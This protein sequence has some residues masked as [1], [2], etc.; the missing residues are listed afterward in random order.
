MRYHSK[1]LL[2]QM[3]LALTSPA[4]S[5]ERLEPRLGQEPIVYSWVENGS[6]VDGSDCQVH[7]VLTQSIAS[8]G[9]KWYT[10][11][12]GGVVYSSGTTLL[13]VAVLLDCT[14]ADVIYCRTP[15]RDL[16]AGGEY[17]IKVTY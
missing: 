1:I 16:P 2:P 4:I 15:K 8:F 5:P 10:N 13:M 12:D 7:D 9:L 17:R 3:L 6:C 14:V 11:V